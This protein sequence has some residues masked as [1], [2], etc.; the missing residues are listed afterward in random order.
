[1]PVAMIIEDDVLFADR[2]VDQLRERLGQVRVDCPDWQVLYLGTFA[3]HRDWA[4][5]L[6]ES[7]RI[8]GGAFR[9]TQARLGC[10]GAYAYLVTLEAAKKLTSL[11]SGDPITMPVDEQLPRLCLRSGL[12]VLWLAPPLVWHSLSPGGGALGST[13]SAPQSRG[14]RASEAQTERVIA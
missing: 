5:K 1:V 14:V 4:P 10:P 9:L 2:F 13:V 7:E 6:L 12:P 3:G 8:S 11:L